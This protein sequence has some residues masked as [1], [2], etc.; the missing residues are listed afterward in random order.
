MD[1]ETGK[2]YADETSKAINTCEIFI[3]LLT[4]LTMMWMK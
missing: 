4:I 2:D 3:L 1:I